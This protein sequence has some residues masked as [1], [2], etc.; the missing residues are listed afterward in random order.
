MKI[1]RLVSII[2]E[3]FTTVSLTRLGMAIIFRI[4]PVSVF[5]NRDHFSYHIGHKLSLVVTQPWESIHGTVAP[6]KL[7]VVLAS[8]SKHIWEKG[9]F[10]YTIL[11]SHAL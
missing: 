9:I 7:S 1:I 8:H 3:L 10:H 6:R 11:V 2:H 4:L 5:F